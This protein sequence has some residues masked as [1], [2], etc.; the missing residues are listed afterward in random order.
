MFVAFTT[1]ALLGMGSPMLILFGIVDLGGALWTWS[2]LKADARKGHPNS[3]A[4]ASRSISSTRS[5]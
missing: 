1:F 3:I 5:L 2:A 4:S